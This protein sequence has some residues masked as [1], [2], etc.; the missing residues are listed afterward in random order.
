MIA[1]TV[2]IKTNHL[3]GM[4]GRLRQ[5]ERDIRMKGALDLGAAAD[6]WT[7][8]LTGAL[9]GNKTMDENG[10]WWHQ[11]YAAHQNFGTV[12]GITPK[13]F[14]EHGYQVAVPPMLA[15]MRQIEGQLV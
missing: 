4:D 2:V 15:A 9:R 14:A 11:G 10:V 1:A 8:V 5:A 7:P 13:G 6:P 3:P 12:R